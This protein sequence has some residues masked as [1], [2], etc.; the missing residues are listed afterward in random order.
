MATYKVIQDVEAEDKI[1]GPLS[2]KQ[3]IFAAIAAG[4][5]FIAFRIVVATGVIY[6]AIPFLPFILVFGVLAAPLGRDQPT[7]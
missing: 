7:E 4:S 1:L 6:T 3:L 5:I 2:L